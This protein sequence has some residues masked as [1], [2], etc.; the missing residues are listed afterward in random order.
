M[1]TA[2]LAPPRPA[3]SP[4]LVLWHWLCARAAL[5]AACALALREPA[6]LVESPLHPTTL[7]CAHLLV[8]GFLATSVVGAFQAVAPLALRLPI[9]AD[10]RDGALLVALV[11]TACGVASHMW[12]S[13]YSGVAWS[14]ALL[15]MA[16]LLRLP[17]WLGALASAR[18]PGAIRAGVAMAWLALPL[19]AAFGI[20]NAVHFGRPFL[21]SD[22]WQ[23]LVG[24]AHLGAG[25]FLLLMVVALGQRLL[26]MFLPAAPPS[27]RASWAAVGLVAIGSYGLGAAQLLLP[28][29]GPAFGLV[30]AAGVLA[31]V[32]TVAAMGL[33]P[34]PAPKDLPRP[35]A[36]RALV[37]MAMLSLLGCVGLGVAL[38]LGLAWRPAPVLAYGVLGLL[39]GL[40][41]MVL[42]IGARIL[43][44]AGWHAAW[45]DV[46]VPAAP[47][48]P[49]RVGSPALLWITAVAWI[50]GVLGLVL[51]IALA[52][53]A[54][55][56]AAVALLAV[57]AV[58]D[59]AN[60][61]RAWRRRHAVP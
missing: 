46:A 20:A 53:A 2:V 12:L 4:R 1:E 14:G 39:G 22:R 44:L 7:A 11:L 58:A 49:R 19:T 52:A 6:A 41:S 59:T 38:A 36:A 57:A 26:P 34:K 33:R 47:A 45:H 23:L 61:V 48:A 35:D 3:W 5:L 51:A 29:A 17:S 10:W 42:G 16:L 25:G 55:S 60:V 32:G 56:G 54:V 8:V 40:G 37:G 13:T 28:A 31:F 50:G 24:H 9:A 18:L 21:G 15:L 43:P 27:P 30:L